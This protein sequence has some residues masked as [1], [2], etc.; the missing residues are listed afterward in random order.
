[1]QGLASNPAATGSL[2]SELMPEEEAQHLWYNRST[3]T[4]P[5]HI[6]YYMPPTRLASTFLSNSIQADF[7]HVLLDGFEACQSL[8][9]TRPAYCP[10]AALALYQACNQVTATESRL[11]TS[12]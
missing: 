12:K 9:R 11:K 5:V 7:R 6:S 3:I 4:A 2:L 10:A 8:E 1:M